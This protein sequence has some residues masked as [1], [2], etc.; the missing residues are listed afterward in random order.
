MAESK[1]NK[2]KVKEENVKEIKESKE[3]KK[4][5]NVKEETKVKKDTVKATAVKG[6]KSTA[7]SDV[8]ID[9]MLQS[10]EN[11][12]VLQLSELVKALEEKFGVSAQAAA[13]PVGAGGQAQEAGAE[14]EKTEFDVYLKSIGSKKIQVIKVVRSVT[15]LGLK[16]AKDVVDK[17]PGMVKE[18]I[19]KD[20]AENI[21]KQLE[22]A[23]AE[24][25][26]K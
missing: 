12:S 7:K 17:A 23:G 19:S 21:K 10:I 9:K 6:Q 11:M 4:M 8:S 26:L 18:K 22:E 13:A 16:E 3:K 2:G 1:E 20:E 15:T 14:E 24:V 5:S 25:E